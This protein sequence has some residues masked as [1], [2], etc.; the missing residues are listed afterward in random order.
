M[1]PEAVPLPP[2]L[3]ACLPPSIIE[4]PHCFIV[5]ALVVIASA[6]AGGS[7]VDRLLVWLNT[8]EVILSD[9]LEGMD[10]GKKEE[11]HGT[12]QLKMPFTR[13][14]LGNR[15]SVKENELTPVEL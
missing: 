4:A 5:E 13:L 9:G 10:R 8:L 6:T 2:G 14:S 12:M 7:T 1:C 11:K 3:I 15:G